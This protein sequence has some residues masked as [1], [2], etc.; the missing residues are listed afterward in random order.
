MPKP[1]RKS[2]VPPV[3]AEK[4][5]RGRPKQA[6]G[7]LLILRQLAECHK[8]SAYELSKHP[9]HAN[10]QNDIKLDYRAVYTHL[11]NLKKTGMV[12]VVES[13][14]TSKVSPR[15]YR[16]TVL[17]LTELIT[18]LTKKDAKIVLKQAHV[19]DA[20]PLLRKFKTEK[21]RTILVKCL[22]VIWQSVTSKGE[23]RVIHSLSDSKA[24]EESGVLR[25]YVGGVLYQNLPEI[26]EKAINL[27]CDEHVHVD[28][29]H[30]IF[31]ADLE[32]ELYE[33][34]FTLPF[35]TD[36]DESRVMKSLRRLI[37]NDSGLRRI[38]LLM[39]QNRMQ[40]VGSETAR[41]ETTRTV[42]L[43]GK[44]RDVKT[45]ENE[46]LLGALSPSHIISYVLGQPDEK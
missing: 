15:F 9:K 34:L 44:A 8:A 36:M 27:L 20:F 18:K 12:K 24:L 19:Q 23:L 21:A 16:L 3:V 46:M 43:E 2:Y 14:R 35:M 37:L 28:D 5:A 42:L 4:R 30:R 39:I 40:L 17:G 11:Q 10:N 32:D 29:L 26:D 31:V 45:V 13:E 41:L 7:R 38:A 25:A 33:K 1:P 22:Q 6:F